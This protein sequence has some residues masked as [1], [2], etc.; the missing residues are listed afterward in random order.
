[1]GRGTHIC[2]ALLAVL[3]G[4]SGLHATQP[5]PV[6]VTPAE[7]P[8]VGSATSQPTAAAASRSAEPSNYSAVANAH[9][10]LLANE[11]YTVH[12]SQTIR[13]PETG[14]RGERQLSG[15]FVGEERFHAEITRSGSAF[16]AE[17]PTVT[18][19]FSDG[20]QVLRARG[21]GQSDGVVVAERDNLGDSTG[22]LP[23][24]PQFASEL[25]QVFA[26]T[27]VVNLTQL[28]RDGR[29]YQRVLVR[30]QGPLERSQP[31]P[32]VSTTVIR[33]LTAGL[34]IDE[35][36]F[37]QRF[38]VRYEATFVGQ[39]VVVSLSARYDAV[40][41]TT[42]ERPGWAAPAG[43]GRSVGNATSTARNAPT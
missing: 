35:R 41:D 30:V 10:S 15:R 42:V 39:P 1:M 29:P 43:Q 25:R 31:P 12:A 11:S 37:V 7:V 21:A 33:N 6:S 14:R 16:G 27:R 5:E 8:D 9:R 20:Q 2:V 28:E 17:A 34:V 38:R 4:C 24:D 23:M 22:A 19:Y 36:G 13:Y 3:A 18:R 26:T 40:G 32:L